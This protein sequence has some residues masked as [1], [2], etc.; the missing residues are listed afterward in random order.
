MNNHCNALPSLIALDLDGTLLRTDKTVSPRTLAALEACKQ[1]GIAL[2]IAS[3][4]GAS[5]VAMI[6][7]PIFKD[8]L[9]ITHN[10][11]LA[12]CG[13][14]ILHFDPIPHS[15]L[16]ACVKFAYRFDPPLLMSAEIDGRPSVSRDVAALWG[17]GFHTVDFRSLGAAQVA[18]ALIQWPAEVPA[19][20]L[21]GN[22]PD[23]VEILMDRD[24][25]AHV[26]NRGVSKH[27]ALGL[28]LERM[29]IPWSAVTAIGDDHT[30]AGMLHL[31]GIG[32]AMGNA[33]P[34][35]RT[36]ANR[37]AATND[38][39]GVARI[40]EELL[41]GMHHSAPSTGAVAPIA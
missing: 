15:A 20:E 36:A 5:S 16:E 3:A 31:A 2:C 35:A 9:W 41:D 26:Q 19:S 23:G 17:V 22:L 7:P 39:D 29:S 14:E 18:K 34:A 27:H 6:A 32:V 8:C 4:R 40:L 11:A 25:Y 13:Q 12:V 1:A 24:G 38:Q 30:D 37:T 10:G 28:C 21:A 33:V